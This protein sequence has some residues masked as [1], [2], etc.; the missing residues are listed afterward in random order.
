[1]DGYIQDNFG[2]SLKKMNAFAKFT[3]PKGVIFDSTV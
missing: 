3:V 1:M 2:W